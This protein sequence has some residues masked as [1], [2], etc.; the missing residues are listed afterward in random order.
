MQ[1][2]IPQSYNAISQYNSIIVFI[3][4]NLNP[5]NVVLLYNPYNPILRGNLYNIMLSYTM[6]ELAQYNPT[7]LLI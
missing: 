1:N 6:I 3:Q 2:T 4:C 5:H 7:K